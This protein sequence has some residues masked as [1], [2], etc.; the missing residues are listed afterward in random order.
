MFIRISRPAKA[1]FGATLLAAGALASAP[2]LAAY[3]TQPINFVNP[4]S[5][6]GPS[7][8]LGRI[9]SQN[10]S[11]ILG[12]Q[13]IVQN[14]P[15]AGAA[16]GAAYVAH[17]SPDGYTM[18]IGTAAAH[19]VS[20]LLEKTPYDGIKDF[21][22]VGMIAN[23]PNVL[24]VYP[25]TGI[26]TVKQL[27][28]ESKAHP[29][30]FSY[31]SAGNGSSP[32]L[33]G[34]N[35]K[36]VTGAKMLHV[37]YKGAAP[38]TTDMVSGLVQVGFM[39]LPAVL[40]FVK[41]GKLHALAIAASSRSPTLPDVPTFAQLG[42]SGFE[43]SSWYSLAVPA[44]T[45][46]AVVQT[47]Y[48]ALANTMHDPKIL[49]QLAAQGIEPFLMDPAQTKAFIIKDQQRIKGLLKAAHLIK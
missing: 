5:A 48:S 43:G 4:Y 25:A 2:G 23:I 27:I 33:T 47:L 1:L 16:I 11:K 34:E 38:A 20:P 24:T 13:F 37:P 45:P 49:K 29:D 46:D 28:Q 44:K 35:F 41:S 8:I 22:F 42:Y 31:A 18:L 26:T 30:K 21:K 36:L 19:A 12:Q 32:H 17:A 39:N 3:P 9:V 14:K 6:G 7:D 15:G 40:P 10:M